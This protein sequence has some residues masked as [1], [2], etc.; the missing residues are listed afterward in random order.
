MNFSSMMLIVFAIIV[1]IQLAYYGAFLFAF[2][3]HKSLKRK[4][5]IALTVIVCAKNE[6]ENL[7]NN[8]PL[9]L[10][11]QYPTFEVVLVND[12]STDDTL[13]VMRDF[14]SSNDN[15]RIVDVKSNEA[16]WGNKKYALTLGI[17]AS[18]NNF[19]VF[20]DADCQPNSDQWLLQLSSLFSNQ[21][22]IV[23]GYGGYTKQ[24]LSFLNKLI[25]FE[26]VFTALQYFSY[27]ILGQ[28]Y[29]GV[30]RNLAYR[31]EIF[32]NNSGFSNHMS[33]LSGDDDLF[34][35]SVA[36]KS[37][38]AVSL[39]NRSFT[40]SMPKTT[41]KEWLYQ[42]RRHVSTAKHYK[43]LHKFLLGLFYLTQL[44]FW[45]MIPVCLFFNEIYTVILALIGIRF[46]FQLSALGYAAKIFKEI[47]ILIFTPLLELFLI[48]LQLVIFIT[49]QISKPGHWK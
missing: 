24:K 25:R 32:F 41:F 34:I 49:N 3:S 19:L 47:D 18:D 39:D 36:T 22:S 42:K 48:I 2:L 20:T 15:V 33:I 6:A 29:M 4:K 40:S 37:N 45:I 23:L 35:N 26:T 13:A 28:P 1:C 9:L 10:N 31:K 8:V 27:A 17:K 44:L 12:G 30:G 38:T 16:F 21:K 11:Q 46:I 14:K 5:N 7:K 43:S